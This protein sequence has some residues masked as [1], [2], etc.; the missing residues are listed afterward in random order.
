MSTYRATV[1][2]ALLSLHYLGQVDAF[3]LSRDTAAQMAAHMAAMASTASASTVK[4][5]GTERSGTGYPPGAG[6]TAY[7]GQPIVDDRD[8][9]QWMTGGYGGYGGGYGGMPMLGFGGHEMLL[10]CLLVVLG[11]GVVGLPFLLLIF[12]AFAGGA[13]GGLNFIPP[14]T[15][16][17]V[18]GRRKREIL[19]HLF[20]A[21]NPQSQEKLL[22]VLTNFYRA[23]DKMDF[24][25]KLVES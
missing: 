17:T 3:G 23:T 21:T 4:A 15:T 16:T 20:P 18:A 5:N 22:E 1:M 13:G 19:A 2:L 10:T 24:F 25:K 7:Y 6:Y 12:S 9:R 11:I 14:T 8:P